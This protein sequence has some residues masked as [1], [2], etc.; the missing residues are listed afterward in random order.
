MSGG[1][2]KS[3]LLIATLFVFTQVH[4]YLHLLHIT[5]VDAKEINFDYRFEF[6][7]QNALFLLC[8][9]FFR[10]IRGKS[11]GWT[12]VQ[13]SLILGPSVLNNLEQGRTNII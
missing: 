8:L 4:I 5:L 7:M 11:Q 12:M 13:R 1:S 10:L 9:C 2:E 3:N 6:K